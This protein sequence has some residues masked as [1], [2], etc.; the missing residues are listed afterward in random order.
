MICN[1]GGKLAKDNSEIPSINKITSVYLKSEECSY[2]LETFHYVRTKPAQQM[3]DIP[4]TLTCVEGYSIK[5]FFSE[6]KN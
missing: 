1:T 5:D 2:A 3:S 4:F 6:T